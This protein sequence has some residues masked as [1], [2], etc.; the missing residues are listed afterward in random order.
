MSAEHGAHRPR[1]LAITAGAL[2][3]SA[4]LARVLRDRAVKANTLR[5]DHVL[6]LSKPFLGEPDAA[7]QRGSSTP[8]SS[9]R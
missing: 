1:R 4:V 9:S 6:D 3:G 5:Y 8:S 7:D 2:A